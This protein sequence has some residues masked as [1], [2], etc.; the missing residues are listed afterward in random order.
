MA[1]PLPFAGSLARPFRPRKA[2]GQ[3]F[4]RDRGMIGEILSLSAIDPEEHVLEIGP[5]KGAL[6]FPLAARV[7]HLIAVEKDPFL[8]EA[9]RARL[10]DQGLGH[11][12]VVTGDILTWDLAGAR[13]A[14]APGF[15]VM[16][17]LPYN[18]SKP[19][20]ER[21]LTLRAHVRRAVLMFQR[22]VGERLTASPGGKAYGAMT[23]L[24][25][26]A[27]RVRPLLTIPREAF[28]PRPKVD[29]MVVSL[30]FEAPYPRRAADELSLTRLIKGAFA[31]RR[32][33]LL[34]ALLAA[35][36][37]RGRD[38]LLQALAHCGIAPARRAE[39]LDMEAFLCLEEALRL[40]TG[41]GDG[42]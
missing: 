19:V 37:G 4:L 26:Y 12:E 18:I 36:Q 31:Y 3:H 2:L 21:L 16:G 5:G 28:H 10:R 23:L 41:G 11:V 30:D 32:K 15:L 17:N 34:N 27:A 6:T 8:A 7:R 9:L 22:E 42:T 38:A 39:T 35:L 13:A 33:T 29:S 1:S 25:S 40:T 20:L 24:V 14:G